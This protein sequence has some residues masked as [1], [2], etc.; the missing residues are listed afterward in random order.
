MQVPG[1]SSLHIY[2][3]DD[4]RCGIS[5]F[6]L[7]DWRSGILEEIHKGWKKRMRLRRPRVNVAFL[8]DFS[9]IHIATEFFFF[10]K[11]TFHFNRL[12]R[13]RFVVVGFLD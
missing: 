12:N 2:Q 5:N 10:P 7:A 9:I 1:P 6:G 11:V 13:K 3:P 8:L 4:T